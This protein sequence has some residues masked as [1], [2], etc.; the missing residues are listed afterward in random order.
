MGQTFHG[1][2][3]RPTVAGQ[4]QGNGGRAG[5]DVFQFEAVL[6]EPGIVGFKAWK[7]PRCDMTGWVMPIWFFDTSIFRASVSDR[8]SRPRSS[9]FFKTVF[10]VLCLLPMRQPL[11]HSMQQ[12][13]SS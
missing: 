10:G 2:V 11:R 6:A 7:A 3:V 12:L 8:S 9:A 13:P 5:I 1:P 4:Q